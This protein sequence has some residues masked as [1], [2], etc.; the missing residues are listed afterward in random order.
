MIS[1]DWLMYISFFASTVP[2]SGLD[3]DFRVLDETT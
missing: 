1:D 2:I 3:D